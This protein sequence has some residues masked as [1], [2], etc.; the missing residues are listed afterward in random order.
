MDI[1]YF[2]SKVLPDLAQQAIEEALKGNWTLA[3]SL[4]K[5]LLS[6]NSKDTE[7]LNRLA[8]AYLELGRAADSRTIYKRVLRIDNYNTIAQKALSRLTNIKRIKKPKNGQAFITTSGDS[9]IE[10][11]GKTK[12]ITLIHLG[13]KAVI[14]SLDSGD[15][16]NLRPHRHRV[17]VETRDNLYI[18]RIPDD[19]SRRLIKLIRE[20]NV[21]SS[22]VRSS[23]LGA[24]RIFVREEARSE[25]LKDVL[26]FPIEKNNFSAFTPPESIHTD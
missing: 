13:D 2:G 12:T 22:I 17:S 18:G 25:K 1:L 6:Q 26:S 15:P 3:V 16:V 21:Y 7:A 19:L 23:D 9:F 20:G 10:E 5:E 24:V 4:N 14:T 11:P 8:R